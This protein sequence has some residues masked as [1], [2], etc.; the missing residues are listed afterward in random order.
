MRP[1]QRQVRRARERPSVAE[2]NRRAEE[3]PRPR[4]PLLEMDRHRVHH[5]HTQSLPHQQEFQQRGDYLVQDDPNTSQAAHRRDHSSVTGR[6]VP[7]ALDRMSIPSLDNYQGISTQTQYVEPRYPGPQYSGS[8][9][10][11]Y[12]GLESAGLQQIHGLNSTY[13]PIINEFGMPQ[14]IDEI[15]GFQDGFGQ[16]SSTFNDQVFG[17]PHDPQAGIP[18]S[19]APLDRT[20]FQQGYINAPYL[21]PDSGY[22]SSSQEQG[23]SGDPFQSLLSTPYLLPAPLPGSPTQQP[24]ITQDP[25]QFPSSGLLYPV[26]PHEQTR[27]RAARSQGSNLYADQT[28][29][30]PRK[31][32]KVEHN[33]RGPQTQ[34]EH[35]ASTRN[36]RNH[37][38][39]D[40]NYAGNIN[41]TSH[42]YEN[43]QFPELYHSTNPHQSLSYPSGTA[44]QT[45]TSGKRHGARDLPGPALYDPQS[46]FPDPVS[47]QQLQTPVRP[48]VT[49]HQGGSHD[50]QGQGS[51]KRKRRA[52][53][54][55]EAGSSPRTPSHTT[56]TTD[57]RQGHSPKNDIR[58]YFRPQ[59]E[60]QTRV[61]PHTSE[62][63]DQS[64]RL[65][66]RRS[67]QSGNPPNLLGN[68]RGIGATVNPETLNAATGIV[69]IEQQ[70]PYRCDTCGKQYGSPNGLKFHYENHCKR[71]DRDKKAYRRQTLSSPKAGSS[72]VTTDHER[73]VEAKD[74]GLGKGVPHDD[75]NDNGDDEQQQADNAQ[76][77]SL[78]TQDSGS[79]S[80]PPRRLSARKRSARQ[81]GRYIGLDACNGVISP[82]KLKPGEGPRLPS[83]SRLQQPRDAGAKCPICG[84]R[85][86]QNHHLKQHFVACVKANGNPDGHYWDDML[87]DK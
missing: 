84:E 65:T 14:V 16:S 23:T 9:Y 8:Q 77:T 17:G 82:S 40:E 80:T 42:S 63:Q 33:L 85:F 72:N 20:S 13:G 48:R 87:E 24:A 66:K 28:T 39:I 36:E 22:G 29:I 69:G 79:P 12:P 18:N 2:T 45:P 81:S 34:S 19:M 1:G 62:H 56:S 47:Q 46:N 59:Q 50:S 54:S 57:Q 52:Y 44:N 6:I 74:I 60:K 75:Q 32:N 21:L 27:S 64:R 30:D 38:Q 35:R 4:H 25:Y 71:E 86:R 70:K 49:H 68:N 15:P 76:N 7:Q 53:S 67:S 41:P 31:L 37:H 5:R 73:A 58:N 11:Q 61:R 83:W 43:H 3:P 78:L 26:T 10:P 51:E 55:P